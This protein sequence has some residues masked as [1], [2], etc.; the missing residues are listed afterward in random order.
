[1]GVFAPQGGA[2][3]FPTGQRAFHGAVQAKG[4]FYRAAAEDG[5]AQGIVSLILRL[6]VAQ[7]RQFVQ[8]FGVVAEW[9]PL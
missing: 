4:V 8:H 2:V 9:V 1:M 6:V 7:A 3:V 5:D